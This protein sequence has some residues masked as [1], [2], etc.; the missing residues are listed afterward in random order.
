VV[1]DSFGIHHHDL[2]LYP[3]LVFKKCV[4]VCV[5]VCAC[6]SVCLNFPFL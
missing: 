4:C 6:M 2:C 1:A 3:H 5:C